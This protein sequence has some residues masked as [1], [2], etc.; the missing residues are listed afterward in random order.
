MHDYDGCCADVTDRIIAC[1]IEVH[2]HLGPGLLESVY[3]PAMCFELKD[4]GLSFHRQVG[5]PVNYKGELIAEHRPDLVVSD[6]VVVEIKSVERFK[7]V[8]VAQMLTYLEITG[9]RVGLILNFNRALMRDGI[10]RVML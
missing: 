1:A 5:V 7:P 6:L 3:E 2:R 9:L 10:K 8:F 4:A